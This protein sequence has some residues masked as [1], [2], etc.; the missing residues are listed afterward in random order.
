MGDKP[1]WRD[2]DRKKDGSYY[3]QSDTRNQGRKGP[4]L[5]TATANYKRQL[6]AYRGVV[7]DGLKLPAGKD[8]A[9]N[10]RQQKLR[11]IRDA[12]RKLKALDAFLGD[13]EILMNPTVWLMALEHSKTMFSLSPS[14]IEE[15]LGTGHPLP[16]KRFIERLKGLEF[17]SFD[18]RVQSK[19][20]ALANQLRNQG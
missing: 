11:A 2:R 3:G 19:A 17:A 13:F 5:E 10:E 16:R 12:G 8:E 20:V 4:R 18:P 14:K 6:D 7:P 9:P 1:S 15:Y